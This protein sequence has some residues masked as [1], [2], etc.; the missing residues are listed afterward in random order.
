[1][2]AKTK[3]LV[4][5]ASDVA[6]VLKHGGLRLPTGGDSRPG[7]PSTRND[8]SNE[9]QAQAFVVEDLVSRVRAAD[10]LQ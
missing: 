4:Y 9:V 1:V 5:S 7:T 10:L 2:G 6:E 8:P 3:M